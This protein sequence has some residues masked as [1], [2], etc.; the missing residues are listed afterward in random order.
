MAA[1][2][3]EGRRREGGLGAQLAPSCRLEAADG[4]LQ[5][6]VVGDDGD[7]AAR[8][9]GFGVGITSS[10]LW[11]VGGQIFCALELE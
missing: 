8:L 3:R 9:M 7:R 2:S 4:Q 1:P 6:V 5:A 10:N 11:L